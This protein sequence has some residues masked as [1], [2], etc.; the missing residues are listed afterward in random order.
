MQSTWD[1]LRLG[2]LVWYAATLY[3][4]RINNAGQ[5]LDWRSRAG[6]TQRIPSTNSPNWEANG[7]GTNLGSVRFSQAAGGPFFA[8]AVAPLSSLGGGADQPF[9]ILMTV[10]QTLVADHVLVCW[11]DTTPGSAVSNFRIDNT[12]GG[13]IRYSRTDNGG[14]TQTVTASADMGLGH[15]RVGMAF[16]GVAAELFTGRTSF[17]TG[18]C[19]VDSMTINRFRFGTGPVID[20]FTG[21]FAELVVVE[22]PIS[23]A[24]WQAYFDYSVRRWGI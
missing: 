19:D 16:T 22:R 4:L 20:A 8:S 17:T 5:V 23:R 14:V 10:Q 18:A 21:N 13:R 7:W 11:D 3:D 2:P 24:E 15:Q 12:G 6:D 9:S 1:P